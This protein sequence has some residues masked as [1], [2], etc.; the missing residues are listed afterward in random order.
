M[1]GELPN[2]A[3]GGAGAAKGFLEGWLLAFSTKRGAM[4]AD[5]PDALAA[6]V[7]FQRQASLRL[8]VM[9]DVGGGGVAVVLVYLLLV[10]SLLVLA[11]VAIC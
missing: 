5:A 1:R 10:R 11:G 2:L 8:F 7:A 3:A 4:V 9:G 6:Q